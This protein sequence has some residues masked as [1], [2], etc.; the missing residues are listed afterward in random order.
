MIQ[1]KQFLINS[2]HRLENVC[3]LETDSPE[4]RRR[5]VT[6]VVIVILSC[7]EGIVSILNS[8]IQGAAI[9]YML[10]PIV[11][12]LVVGTG[13]LSFYIT[14]RFVLLLYPF[15]LM[16]LCV[17][18]FFQWSVGGFSQPGS[19]PIIIWSLLAPFGAL[20]F[21]GIRKALWWLLA[22]LLLVIGSL[23]LDEHIMLAVS[24]ATHDEIVISQGINIIGLSITIFLTMY[25]FFNA[26]Q[27]E[28]TRA[29]N[30]LQ[31]L[32]E[33]QAELVHSEKMAALGKLVAGL[34]HEANTPLGAIQS[35]A[36]VSGRSVDKIQ[37]VLE[38][39]QTIDEIKGNKPLQNAMKTLRD[40]QSVSTEACGRFSRIIE[41]L[42]N[43]ARLDESAFQKTNLLLG[44]ESTLT[45]LEAEFADRI[46][47][48]REFGDIPEIMCYPGELN[49]A[50]MNILMNASQAI[51][52]KGTIT[53]RTYMKDKNV[54]IEIKDNGVGIP[55]EKMGSLFNP[56]FTRKG[57]RVKAGLGL[58]TS[59]N[60]VQKHHGSISVTSEVGKGST[61]NIVISRDLR[62]EATI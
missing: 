25:Y 9:L 36:D 14:K 1:I 57:R 46:K 50:F 30:A 2:W 23:S 39:S 49:Q 17:P 7:L 19:N 34:V 31:E 16:I 41:S 12:I 62:P 44:L 45:L 11:F 43:F 6:L 13:L 53:I 18:V 10:S 61:F 3:V 8:Y 55:T 37:K 51:P 56:S 33:T 20:M 15:L 40:S 52:Q 26:F 35:T 42:K 59:L 21:L 4:E 54:H 60:I 22:Y 38:T 47:V 32:K 24:P 48:I 27:K 5:K 29:E 58:F 28:H